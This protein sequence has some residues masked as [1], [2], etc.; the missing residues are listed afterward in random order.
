MQRLRLRI[1]WS[2]Q[3]MRAGIKSKLTLLK[4]QIWSSRSRDGSS[5][6]PYLTIDCR[7]TS[8]MQK[9]ARIGWHLW[10]LGIVGTLSDG[11][12]QVEQVD[13]TSTGFN[14]CPLDSHSNESRHWHQPSTVYYGNRDRALWRCFRQNST[15]AGRKSCWGRL[16]QGWEKAT[17]E[18]KSAP[19]YLRLANGK[20]SRT[21]AEVAQV[22][23]G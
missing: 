18:A 15:G 9:Y 1:P 14:R 13:K 5:F 8:F 23:K 19:M 2:Q 17:W 16:A 3:V 11:Y 21:N 20:V 12:L 4:D 6:G 10:R 7:H 22:D